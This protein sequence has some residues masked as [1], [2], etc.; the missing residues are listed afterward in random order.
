MI[1][2]PRRLS[3]RALEAGKGQ[4]RRG[5]HVLWLIH[6]SPALEVAAQKLLRPIPARYG[7]SRQNFII[8]P[9]RYHGIANGKE[10]IRLRDAD[11]PILATMLYDVLNLLLDRCAGTAGQ[12]DEVTGYTGNG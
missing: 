10:L 9:L 8:A 7:L 4:I 5:F 12:D 11:I 3:V 2:Q 6:S 1:S